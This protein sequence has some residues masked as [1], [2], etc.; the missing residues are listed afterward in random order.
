M[1]FHPYGAKNIAKHAAEVQRGAAMQ[2]WHNDKGVYFCSLTKTIRTFAF[3]LFLAQLMVDYLVVG[4]GIA[5]SLLSWHL[6]ELGASVVAANCFNPAAASHVAAGIINPITGRRVVKARYVDEI[7]AHA[8]GFYQKVEEILGVRVYTNFPIYRIFRSSD[9]QLLWEQRRTRPDY[10]PSMGDTIPC[11][12]LPTAIHAP[13]GAGEIIGGGWVQL[14]ALLPALHNALPHVQSVENGSLTP[15]DLSWNGTCVEWN[16]I[17]AKRV[18]FCEGWR[19][20]HNPLFSFLPFLPSFGETVVLSAP[21]LHT[22][23]I[24]NA[25]VHIVPLGNGLFKVGAT[26]KWDR[27]SEQPTEEG[28]RELVEKISAVLAT[29]FH[30]VEHTAGIRPSIADRRPVA[31]LHPH[32][33]HIGILNGLGSKGVSFGPWAAYH[34]AHFLVNNTP[35]PPF[36][37]IAR[38]AEKISPKEQ[39]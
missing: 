30:I 3:L 26:N 36:I 19:A 17:T 29:P 32:Y 39:P 24:L 4:A 35:L 14:S 21:E 6:Q 33:P 15:D 8:Q 31:G 11:N 22:H 9:E 25:D 5:G 18:V 7:I 23:A 1:Q 2:H 20:I 27:T 38:F 37:D 34:F 13:L 16:G 12:D 10:A 28:K